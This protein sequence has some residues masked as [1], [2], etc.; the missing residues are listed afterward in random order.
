MNLSRLYKLALLS[1]VLWGF[2]EGLYGPLYA[3][4]VK[5]I[6]GS[7]IDIGIAYSILLIVQG[8][9]MVPFG[10]LSDKYG[11]K[12]FVIAAGILFAFAAFLYA[13]WVSDVV[14]VFLTQALIG[15][16][17]AM[18]VP[19]WSIIMF[20]VSGKKKTAEKYGALEGSIYVGEGVAAIIGSAIAV[21]I[22]FQVLFLGVAGLMILSTVAVVFM[23][24][25]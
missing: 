21:F 14:S 25:K 6:G 24:I 9:L 7:F 16:S 4:F 23:D 2:G 10:Q 19:A 18:A 22:S 3:I 20:K 5:G 12:P 8:L 13:F 17:V 1:D 11:K 15:L